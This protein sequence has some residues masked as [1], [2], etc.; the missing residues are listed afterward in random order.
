MNLLPH[1][2]DELRR[3]GLSDD[4]LQAAG[5]YSERDSRKVAAMLN[6]K[7]F[8]QRCLPCIVYPYADA[9]GRNGYC[10]IKPDSPRKSR[11]KP[12]KYESPHERGNEIYLP[13]GVAAVLPDS[14]REL[15]V[16]EGEKKALCAT[17]HGFPCIGLVG[18][19]GWHPK[20]N[21]TLLLALERVAW[22]GRRV[23]IVFDNDGTPKPNVQD[24][25][26]RLAAHLGT[27]GAVVKIVC[28]PDGAPGPDGK[29]V[30]VGL[31]DFLVA[32]VA[33]GLDPAGELRRLLDLAE[34]P[35]PPD[36]GTMRQPATEIDA[37][38]DA[39][40]FLATT[41]RDGLPRLRF[42]RATWL[43]WRG[44]AYREVPPS[45]IRAEVVNFLDRDYFKLTQGAVGNVLDGL[46]AKAQLSH[47]I[48]PPAWIGDGGP[49]SDPK[50]I[51]VCRNGLV[52]LPTLTAGKQDYLLPA[53]PRLF[54]LSALQFEFD[55]QRPAAGQLAALPR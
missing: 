5:I 6:Y 52:H 54:A 55:P 48:E 41:E 33:K 35:T 27:R 28:L 13:P 9:E 47:R 18:V 53:T 32:A 36:A 4:T 19:F 8:S 23:F 21:E 25:E 31:D 46:R 15:L 40:R 17:Q 39:A 45:E 16:T 30:K 38:P 10:R 3:S 20:N 29:P 14:G 22:S 26:S 11:G 49:D 2:L 24:T 1:H 51:L 50:D 43:A 7:K 34:E 12:V 44:G 37:V 42:W